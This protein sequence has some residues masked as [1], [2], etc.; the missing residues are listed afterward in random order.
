MMS[1]CELSSEEF[2]HLFGDRGD[3][4]DWFDVPTNTTSS[5]N[6][7]PYNETMHEIL[8]ELNPSIVELKLDFPDQKKAGWFFV[9]IT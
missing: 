8:N 7:S 9:H 6:P 1:Y 2:R 5:S 3:L 4:E